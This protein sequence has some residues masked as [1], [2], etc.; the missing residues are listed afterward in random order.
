ML[1]PHGQRTIPEKIN[2]TVCQ[3]FRQLDWTCDPASSSRCMSSRSLGEKVASNCVV[4]NSNS[5]LSRSLW[6]CQVLKKIIKNLEI[7]SEPSPF[8]SHIFKAT[9]SIWLPIW[10]PTRQCHGADSLLHCYLLGTKSPKKWCCLSFTH[11]YI[12]KTPTNPRQ[13]QSV[14]APIM[15]EFLFGK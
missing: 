13:Q 11:Q 2:L 10:K 6:L 7:I 9:F 5:S 4:S 8:V 12:K 14:F 3:H 1:F 15:R